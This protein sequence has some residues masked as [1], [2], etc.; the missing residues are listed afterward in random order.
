MEEGWVDPV[1]VSK[2]KEIHPGGICLCSLL[3][4]QS[5]LLRRWCEVHTPDCVEVSVA[6]LVITLWL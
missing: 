3:C 1:C 6:W 5:H 4:W 2:G